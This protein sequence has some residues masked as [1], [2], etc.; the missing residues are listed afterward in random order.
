MKNIKI[1]LLILVVSYS[2]I[3]P[4]K[5]NQI[6]QHQNDFEI[7]LFDKYT[8]QN[9][10]FKKFIEDFINLPNNKNKNVFLFH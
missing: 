4:N 1:L 5:N 3:K 9:Q 6:L 10:H 7:V 8:F 2:C